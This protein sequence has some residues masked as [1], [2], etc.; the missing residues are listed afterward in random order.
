M[1][2]DMT[3]LFHAIDALHEFHDPCLF[4]GCFETGRLF[5]E[6]YLGFGENAMKE[7]HFYVV[8]LDVPIKGSSDV[9]ESSE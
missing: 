5:H 6:H 1:V 4:A 8:L 7:S 2:P 9:K 3:G